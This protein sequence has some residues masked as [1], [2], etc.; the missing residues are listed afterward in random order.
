LSGTEVVW[1]RGVSLYRKQWYKVLKIYN[2]P[3]IYNNHRCDFS[4]PSGNLFIIA[5]NTLVFNS[6][7]M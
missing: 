2:N 7:N 3:D 4:I 5:S 6:L 1:F